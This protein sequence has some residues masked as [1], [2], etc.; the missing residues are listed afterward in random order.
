LLRHKHAPIECIRKKIIV[1][2]DSMEVKEFKLKIISWNIAIVSWFGLLSRL[3]LKTREFNNV[4]I[5]N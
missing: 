1:F 5:K 3:P 4:K 2:L